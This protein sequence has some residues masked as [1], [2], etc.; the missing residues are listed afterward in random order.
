MDMRFWHGTTLLV[1]CLVLLLGA[2]LRPAQASVNMAPPSNLTTVVTSTGINLSWQNNSVD[3]TGLVVQCQKIDEYGDAVGNW[4]DHSWSC[5]AQDTQFTLQL[6]DVPWLYEKGLT[7]RFRVCGIIRDRNMGPAVNVYSNEAIV[8][9]PVKILVY[10]IGQPSYTLDGVMKPMDVAPLIIQ[11]RTFLPIRYVADPLGAV[12]TWN[13]TENK[14]TVRAVGKTIELWIN[15]NMARVNGAEVMIDPNN[16]SV[17]PVTVPP[18]RTM[19]PLRFIADNL[20]SQV[21]WDAKTSQ[22]EIRG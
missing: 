22:I 10:K 3:Q 2:G 16:S 8:R 21:L 15:N 19:L 18:G 20:G 12:A 6:V 17:M 1:I 14:V 11:G 13:G 5:G 4:S 9:L 7:M